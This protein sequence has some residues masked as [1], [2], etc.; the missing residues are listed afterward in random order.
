MLAIIMS[1][2]KLMKKLDLETL[3]VTKRKARSSTFDRL[4]SQKLA[5]HLSYTAISYTLGQVGDK[6]PGTGYVMYG[7]QCKIKRWCFVQKLLRISK[8]R[9]QSIKWSVGSF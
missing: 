4:H 9:G 8:S 7:T 1:L 6:R 3:R 5:G 2:L